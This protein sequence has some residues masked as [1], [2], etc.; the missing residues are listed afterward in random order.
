MR[1]FFRTR[2]VSSPADRPI[3]PSRATPT[4][5]PR[6]GTAFADDPTFQQFH[7]CGEC[8]AHLS[9]GARERIASLVD[10]GSF[11]EHDADLASGDPLHFAD[12]E[13]YPA[14]LR[15]QQRATG[16]SDALIAGMAAIDGL[17]ISLAVLDFSFMGGSMGVVVGEKLVRAAQRAHDQKAPLLTIVA[18]GGARMQEGMF[19]LM[20]MAKT[21]AAIQRLHR[22]GVPHISV[23]TNPTTGGVFASFGSLG[24]IILAEPGAL[25]GFAGPRVVEQFLGK[26]LPPGSHSAEFLLAQG[27]IDA[28]VPRPRH[29]EVLG[30]V[31]A[32]LGSGRRHTRKVPTLPDP[33]FTQNTS[34]AWTA[35]Q[36]AR[37]ELRPT[38]IDYVN[39]IVDEFVEL[40]GD[41]SSGDDPAVIAGLGLLDDCPVAIVAFERGHGEAREERRQGRP[42]PEGFRKA[43]RIMELAARFQLPVISFVDTPGA[44]PG[45]EAEERGLAGEIARTM[46][47]MS[48]LP[49]PI[50]AAVIGE[51]GSGGALALA[52]ADRVLM[53]ESAI[54][55][56]I[57]PEGA[58]A[59]LYR[60]ASRAPEL[61]AKLKITAFDLHRFGM[62]DT[63][64]PEPESGA[65]G[66][67]DRT[68]EL[69][70]TVLLGT[71]TGL[72]EIPVKRLVQLRAE[73][74]RD[75][76]TDRIV[77]RTN[78]ESERAT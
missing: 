77:Q 10:P 30:R 73:R 60:D 19:S 28:I 65:A 47:L 27:M 2:R 70:K 53:Q 25:I 8:G 67:P 18:S 17:R 33:E 51:G 32:L 24:D 7:V 62:V 68:A 42:L 26:P 78:D 56:V 50:V 35:V 44:Y 5:C 54:Y 13:P 22:A 3:S 52:V 15:E 41:R 63:I 64:V 76:G 45:I 57:A 1:R 11:V 12:D 21:T 40:H 55:S 61:A 16:Q 75:I 4:A 6:C 23:L 31:V 72:Q 14:R 66:D 59:I 39:R 71:L 46:A 58:A 43:R 74:Y 9:I 36:N 69:L 20:Q 34:D 49:T 37:S 48:D 29:R 38:S